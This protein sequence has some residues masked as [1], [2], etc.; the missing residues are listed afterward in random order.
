MSWPQ[1]RRDQSSASPTASCTGKCSPGRKERL[2]P[3]TDTKPEYFLLYFSYRSF[4]IQKRIEERAIIKT[5]SVLL[6]Y[7]RPLSFSK[8]T[9]LFA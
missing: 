7:L 2:A 4:A 6:Q 1:D 5:I 8:L 3:K 9:D